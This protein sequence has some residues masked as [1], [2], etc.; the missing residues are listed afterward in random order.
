[1]KRLALLLIRLYP[2]AW[3]KR[4]GRELG[5]LLEDSGTGWFV[6]VD[7]LKEAIKMQLTKWS[8][9]K[10]AAALG[11][12]GL[13]VAAVIAALIPR[14]Y[15][16]DMTMLSTSAERMKQIET[17]VLRR[18]S[19]AN[20]IRNPNLDLYKTARESKP[21][22]DVVENMRKDIHISRV[23]RNSGGSAFHLSFAY[24]DPV[25]AQKTLTALISAFM[26]ANVAMQRQ[27]GEKMEVLDPPSLSFEPV[28]PNVYVIGL[29]GLATG[30]IIAAIFRLV[31]KTT[32]EK[33]IHL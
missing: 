25:K 18:P 23:P 28:K 2:A 33:R 8:F 15:I 13:L 10:L 5:V 3:R 19:L 6:I 20:I 1:M 30:L 14:T 26:E 32:P 9:G 24:P 29:M 7:L 11:A 22:E 17:E 31:C 4:Y 12:A 21:L 16:S 27:T